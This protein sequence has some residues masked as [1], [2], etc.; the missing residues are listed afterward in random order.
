MRELTKRRN[1]AIAEYAKTHTVKEICEAFKIKQASYVYT[2]LKAYNIKPLKRS[3]KDE[4]TE[5]IRIA[6]A[7]HTTMTYEEFIAKYAPKATR[8][9]YYYF[10]SRG[11][12]FKKKSLKGTKR[13]DARRKL[14]VDHMRAHAGEYTLSGYYKTFKPD[15]AR[16]TVLN[17]AK[18]YGIVFK[19]EPPKYKAVPKE[20]WDLA[21][22]EGKQFA[23]KDFYNTYL[24]KSI[25]SLSYFRNECCKRG[26]QFKQFDRSTIKHE[27]EYTETERDII[28]K[29]YP[30]IGVKC[31]EYLPGRSINSVRQFASRNKIRFTGKKQKMSQNAIFSEDEQNTI[32]QYF[33]TMG[34]TCAAM[35][36]N[37]TRQ[38][39]KTWAKAN[40]IV[41][42]SKF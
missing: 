17:R 36:K 11:I 35:L 31:M 21:E 33:P 23:I 42:K 19:K 13:E 2:I 4:K 3:K 7:V 26:I 27:N 25:C 32:R 29:Y 30:E 6:E 14:D 37:K 28:K 8:S 39:V 38:E 20:I 10:R 9:M 1:D 18:E 5:F 12:Y 41:Q 15:C 34:S 24:D 16:T 40:N 22:S